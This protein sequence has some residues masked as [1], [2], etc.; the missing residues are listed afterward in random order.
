MTGE[1]QPTPLMAVLFDMDGV[2]TD[3]AEAH[4]TAWKTLFDDFLGELAQRHGSSF[5]PFD[6]ERDY[7]RYVDGKPRYD[8]V[9][10]F[11]KARGI[12]LARGSPDDPP[13][14]ATIYGLGNRKND[15][16]QQ[17]L[18]NHRVSTYPTTMVLIERLRAAGIAVAIFSSS[19]NSTAVLRNAGVEHL[20][21][22][23]VD[24]VDLERLGLAG[25]PDPAMLA[26]AAA[27]VSA[28][29]DRTAVVEDS[30]AGV[31]AGLRGGFRPVVGI[32]RNGNEGS[33]S[34]AGADLI[35][36][37][38]GELELD[39][40]AMLT[41]RRIDT[42]PSL[43]SC[44][45][46]LSQRLARVRPALFLDYD[47]TL[48]PIVTDPS[49]ADLSPETRSVL[50]ELAKHFKVA[51]ISGRA[52]S[53]L[54]TRVGLDG[55][56]Y[57]GSHGF[58]IAGPDFNYTAEHAQSFRPA[59]D[60]AETRLRKELGGIEGAIVERKPFAIAVHY[61]RAPDDQVSRIET[62]VDA[63]LSQLTDLRKGR[64]KKVFQ[65][66]PRI[67]W[68]K[69]RAVNYVRQLP[70][71]TDC[72][73]VYIGDDLTDEYA[74]RALAGQS[75][76]SI[77]VRDGQRATSAD[78]SLSNPGDVLQFLQALSSIEVSPP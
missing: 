20:F 77:V 1:P 23:R 62:V 3:T 36:A 69:G 34:Q 5:V 63:T 4:A 45:T 71:L 17:W 78:Y 55:L 10:D 9:A 40:H 19:R 51:I 16:F 8:G 61:R 46:E 21:D 30:V 29:P 31:T 7:R 18:N 14:R 6:A 67:D 76:V 33:L 58:E 60:E 12:E 44:W 48:T 56:V 53:D 24:G 11:L 13:D 39:E 2:V 50:A 57:A 47:G 28:R 35:V 43:W 32:N 49:A 74:F 72:T 38:A 27:R 22:A 70:G 59:L 75:G 26:E 54:R 41:V 15:Y 73:P 37:D 68:N 64:G 52:L 25:K 66:L 42:I 65:L